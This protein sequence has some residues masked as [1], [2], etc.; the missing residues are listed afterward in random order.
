MSGHR[1]N[2]PGGPPEK[3]PLH[4]DAGAPATPEEG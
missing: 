3:A 2:A 1:P 4:A